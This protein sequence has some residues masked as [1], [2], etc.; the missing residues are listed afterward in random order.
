[1]SA[2]EPYIHCGNWVLRLIEHN[3]LKSYT[4][5]NTRGSEPPKNS[6]YD[7]CKYDTADIIDNNCILRELYDIDIIIL[8]LSP[9]WI[10]PYYHNLFFLWMDLISNCCEKKFDFI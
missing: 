4:W 8:C 5:L 1:M 9:E 3:K 6:K 2:D 7:N 10:P